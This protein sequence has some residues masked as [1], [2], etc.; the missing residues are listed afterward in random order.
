MKPVAELAIKRP[1]II[2]IEAS[3]LGRGSYPVEV[4]IALP[5]GDCYCAIICPDHE[6][7]HWDQSA[8]QLHGI[9]RST[10]LAHGRPVKEVAQML[11][12]YIGGCVAYSDGWGNDSS[13]LALLFDVAGVAQHFKLDSLRSIMTQAQADIWHQVKDQVI[14]DCHFRRH[15]ASND[16][17]ILQ[18]T[19]WRSYQLTTTQ[20]R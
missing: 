15:R 12:E 16:A 20:S 14:A 10:L 5:D 11:N 6:W 8:E 13:W 9:D 17:Q 1:L 18:Q 3:G 4:G 19:Y 7:Q 2:D